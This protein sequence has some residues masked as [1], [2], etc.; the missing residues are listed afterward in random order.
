MGHSK[1]RRQ[2]FFKA[3]PYCCFC[4]GSRLA[5]TFDHVPGR[6]FFIDRKNPDEFVFPACRKCNSCSQDAENFLRLIAVAEEQDS[7]DRARWQNSVKYVRNRHPELLDSLQMSLRE[8]RTALSKLG[9]ERPRGMAF[10]E[11]PI[12]KLDHD[13][14]KSSIDI[15]GRKLLLA[16]HYQCF[17]KVLPPT[18]GIALSFQS[19]TTV[20][21]GSLLEKFME[22]TDQ[23]AIPKHQNRQLDKQFSIRW[24]AMQNP[25]TAIWAIHLHSRLFYVGVSSEDRN[26]TEF[27]GL[28]LS[29]PFFHSS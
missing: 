25:I 13:L 18:G 21:Q 19:N 11:V 17:G 24:S 16:L 12:V 3:H 2:R 6:A 23:L 8:K 1:D 29:G 10:Q 5:E 7:D 9:L 4:G 26:L 20:G 15:F 22:L 27:K 28:S 14:W